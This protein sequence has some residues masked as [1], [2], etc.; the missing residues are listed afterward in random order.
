MLSHPID[1]TASIVFLSSG[2]TPC[3]NPCNYL[4]VYLLPVNFGHTRCWL[5]GSGVEDRHPRL[6]T[7]LV[8][9]HLYAS[10]FVEVAWRFAQTMLLEKPCGRIL[11]PYLLP[12]LPLSQLALVDLCPRRAILGRGRL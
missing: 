10:L 7:H 2:K 9:I 1:Y 4:S 12:S 8:V 6:I 3:F 5:R 11:E